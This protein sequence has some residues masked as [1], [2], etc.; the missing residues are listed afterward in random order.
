MQQQLAVLPDPL[1]KGLRRGETRGEAALARGRLYEV[2][3]LLVKRA[4]FAA[5][6]NGRVNCPKV[7]PV[8]RSVCNYRCFR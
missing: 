3:R 7:L 5:E 8:V 1:G 4:H 2:P 6:Q